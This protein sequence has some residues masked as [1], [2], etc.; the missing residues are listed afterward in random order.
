ML[1]SLLLLLHAKQAEKHSQQ[2]QR[3]S[4]LTHALCS[5]SLS[6]RPPLFLAGT[7]PPLRCGALYEAGGPRGTIVEGL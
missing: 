1:L 6:P 3:P 2:T 5:S 4:F 7:R